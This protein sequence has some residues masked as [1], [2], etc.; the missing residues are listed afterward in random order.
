MAHKQNVNGL[1]IY[2]HCTSIRLALRSGHRE[3]QGLFKRTP[4]NVKA[5]SLSSCGHRKVPQKN[6]HR[7]LDC[8][9]ELQNVFLIYCEISSLQ[10]D[11]GIGILLSNC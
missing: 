3:R 5:V 6:M 8:L 9:P 10:D 7:L 1:K 11:G 4:E 2:M